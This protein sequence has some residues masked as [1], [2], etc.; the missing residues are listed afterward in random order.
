MHKVPVMRNGEP[1][2]T[3]ESVVEDRTVYVVHC[4]DT[5]GPLYES[6]EAKFERLIDIFGIDLEPTKANFEKLKRK[7]IALGNGLE[8]LVAKTFSG[9]LANFNDTWTKVDDMLDRIL[10]ESFRSRLP[11]SNGGSWV[12]NWFC[13]D[14]VNYVNNPRRRTLGY[15]HIFDHYRQVLADSGS[16][17]DGIHWHFHPMSTYRDAHRCATSYV[18][19]PHLYETL[20]RRIIDREWFPSVF[21]AGFQAER[22][23]S[24]LFLEQWVPFDITNMASKDPTIQSQQDFANGRSGDWRLAPDDWSVYRPSHDN[25]QLRGDCRRYIARA[26]NI[27]NRIAP[28]TQEEVDSAFSRADA[29]RPT[30]MGV[31]CH[32]YR[33]IGVEVDEIRKMLEGASKR[34]PGVRFVYSEAKSAFQKVIYG[35]DFDEASAGKLELD[36]QI[37]HNS[38]SVL[39]KV[40][41]AAGEVFGPQPFLAVRLKSRRYMHDNLDFDTSSGRWFYTFDAESILP[42]DVDTIGVGG[43]DRFGNTSV[44]RMTL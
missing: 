27:L 13:V 2:V 43:A 31:A 24:H 22:P 15:H 40:N 44:V 19:S 12:Y 36:C 9:H 26:L 28:L 41:A 5:E 21:R 3:G 23:D 10:S 35:S 38:K 42:S 16:D 18:N 14:H 25:Y 37:H 4:I 1:L 33:D 17:M 34:F 7:E 29:G 30:L 6:L 20:C 11:D 39:L 8:D 32:D